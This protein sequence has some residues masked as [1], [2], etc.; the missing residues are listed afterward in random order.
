MS[1]NLMRNRAYN[2]VD[3]FHM[4]YPQQQFGA[5]SYEEEKSALSF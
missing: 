3:V 2:D 4:H 5:E 1:L